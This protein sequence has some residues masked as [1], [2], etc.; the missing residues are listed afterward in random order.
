MVTVNGKENQN[1]TS[2]NDEMRQKSYMMFILN[3]QLVFQASFLRHKFIISRD[4]HHKSKQGNI[5]N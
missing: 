3:N 1:D 5:R 4:F 2:I